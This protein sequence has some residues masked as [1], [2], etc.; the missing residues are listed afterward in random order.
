MTGARVR[1]LNRRDQS[2][3]VAVVA[4]AVAVG[5]LA[6]LLARLLVRDR[7]YMMIY[8]IADNYL[9]TV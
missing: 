6:R 4:A 1:G 9:E 5:R 2:E 7:R 3:L 8:G